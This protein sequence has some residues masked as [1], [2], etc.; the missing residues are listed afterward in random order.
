MSVTWDEAKRQRTLAERDLDFADAAQIFAGPVLTI[1]D[2]RL[3]YGELRFQTYG[4]LGE[5]LVMVV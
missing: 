1:A 2:E 3:D 5:R 4:I